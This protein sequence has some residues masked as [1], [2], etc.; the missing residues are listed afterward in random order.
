MIRYLSLDWI[1]ALTAEVAASDALRGLAD[2]VAVGITQVVTGSPEGDVV[3]HLQV[4]DGAATFGAGGAYPEDVKFEQDWD[5]AVAVATGAMNA[6]DA[7]IKGRIT[8]TGDPQKL[9]AAEPVFR[10]LDGVFSS[11]R[12]RT[13]YE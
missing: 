6:Q 9:A 8:L 3:Y 11:V 5:T 10:E 12:E 1:E 4:G 7:F 13:S 2:S